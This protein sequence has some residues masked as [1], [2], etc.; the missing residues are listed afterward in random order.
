M[1]TGTLSS[2]GI[3]VLA[4]LVVGG[5]VWAT[6]QIF[7]KAIRENKE[8]YLLYSGALAIIVGALAIATMGS[9]N[10]LSFAWV[11]FGGWL[12]ANLGQKFYKRYLKN[13]FSEKQA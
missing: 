5:F 4:V 12:A 2:I 3:P 1:E 6:V 11:A 7:K 13:L 10:W 8:R 9:W